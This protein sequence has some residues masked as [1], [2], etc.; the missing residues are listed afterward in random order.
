VPPIIPATYVHGRMHPALP[1]SEAK[2]A[3]R[4][5]IVTA[6][7]SIVVTAYAA[8]RHRKRRSQSHRSQSSGVWRIDR[9]NQLQERLR[10]AVGADINDIRIR[11]QSGEPWRGRNAAALMKC[12]WALVVPPNIAA[13]L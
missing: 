11:G 1:A 5:S 10:R 3:G 13:R 12:I 6:G 2:S 4:R 7:P 9:K 8:I